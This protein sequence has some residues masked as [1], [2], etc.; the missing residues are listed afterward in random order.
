MPQTVLYR[1]N[2]RGNGVV[3]GDCFQARS[4]LELSAQAS[5]RECGE[6][7]AVR[8]ADARGEDEWKGNLKVA[9]RTGLEPVT[10]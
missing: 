5:P 2:E 10:Q 6:K 4:G 3:S 9:P 7:T 1:W 8:Y